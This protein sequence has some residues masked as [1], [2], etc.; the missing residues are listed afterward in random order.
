MNLGEG[1]TGI[2]WCIFL[3]C[4]Y[5][6]ISKYKV[7][8]CMIEAKCILM[9]KLLFCWD[10]IGHPDIQVTAGSWGYLNDRR[11][12]MK[13]IIRW[14][15]CSQILGVTQMGVGLSSRVMNSI[16][17]AV[18]LFWKLREKSDISDFA[19]SFLLLGHDRL[20]R[21]REHSKSWQIG[22]GNN[23]S[24]MTLPMAWALLCSP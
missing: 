10:Y 17:R 20:Q 18:H 22:E 2:Q 5:E 16:R 23:L 13:P 6:I 21:P 3:Q 7:K 11:W 15:E 4:S 12:R 9:R 8:I 24:C 19:A 14:I 1:V